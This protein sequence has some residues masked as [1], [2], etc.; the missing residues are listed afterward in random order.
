MVGIADEHPG[1]DEST[2]EAVSFSRQKGLS[3]KS[4][5]MRINHRRRSVI[6]VA[7]RNKL[8]AKSLLIVRQNAPSIGHRVLSISCPI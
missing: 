2:G 1:E 7:I 5:T 8:G 4:K 6:S 3:H